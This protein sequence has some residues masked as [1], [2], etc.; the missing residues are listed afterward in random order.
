MEILE[1]VQGSGRFTAF[2]YLRKACGLAQ[3]ALGQAV[4][5]PTAAVPGLSV[6]YL[7]SLSEANALLK[8]WDTE[9]KS[10][11]KVKNP[12]PITDVVKT[13]I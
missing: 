12:Y 7:R 3:L 9:V 1:K 11:G 5:S 2:Q 10:Q 13:R 8:S 6:R 4:D